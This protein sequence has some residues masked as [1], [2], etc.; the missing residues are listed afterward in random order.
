MRRPEQLAFAQLSLAAGIPSLGISGVF[1]PI[2]VKEPCKK[3]LQRVI[4][5]H[6]YFGVTTELSR[7]FNSQAPA[8]SFCPV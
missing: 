8:F 1:R 2:R 6:C 4:P 3:L 7:Q 5:T